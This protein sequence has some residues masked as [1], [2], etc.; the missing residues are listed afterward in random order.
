MPKKKCKTNLSAPSVAIVFNILV[1]GEVYSFIHLSV[2]PFAILQLSVSS[3]TKWNYKM[4]WMFVAFFCISF[5]MPSNQSD[6]VPH[7]FHSHSHSHS[8]FPLA[9]WHKLLIYCLKWFL[10]AKRHFQRCWPLLHCDGQKQVPK[11]TCSSISLSVYLAPVK[12]IWMSGECVSGWVCECG[13]MWHCSIQTIK[14]RIGNSPFA[15]ILAFGG[16]RTNSRE[17][18]KLMLDEAV[19]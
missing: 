17:M 13:E 4:C 9:L 1:T 6:W 8:H 2:L 5:C 10:V 11:Y 18:P 3:R 12:Q 16:A 19:N 7:H 14:F 15:C